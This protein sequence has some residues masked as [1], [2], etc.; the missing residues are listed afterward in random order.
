M[1]FYA[2]TRPPAKDID[3]IE[4]LGNP[5]WNWEDF[6]KYSKKSETCAYQFIN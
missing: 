1:N 6:E 3:A 4:Q 2:W 5:G